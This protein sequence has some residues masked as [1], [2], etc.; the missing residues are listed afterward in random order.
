[1]NLRAFGSGIHLECLLTLSVIPPP[2]GLHA[3]AFSLKPV[4]HALIKYHACVKIMLQSVI[5]RDGVSWS[6]LRGRRW[7][8]TAKIIFSSRFLFS[9]LPQKQCF[10]LPGPEPNRVPKESS[11]VAFP[12]VCFTSELLQWPRLHYF[13]SFTVSHPVFLPTL[14]YTPAKQ[15]WHIVCLQNVVFQVLQIS[16]HDHQF[17]IKAILSVSASCMDG[18]LCWDSALTHRRQRGMVEG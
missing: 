1:M 17:S 15:C 4:W 18:T 7:G 5:P 9:R 10:H 2:H 16:Q 3:T 14:I 13:W 11:C 6:P 12:A 8:G